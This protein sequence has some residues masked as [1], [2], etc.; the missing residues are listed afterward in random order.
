MALELPP[1]RDR[2]GDIPEL[3]NHFAKKYGEA[4]GIKIDGIAPEVLKILGEHEWRGNVRE[5]E[6]TMHRAVLLAQG[7]IIGP[8]AIML[9]GGRG[10]PVSRAAEATPSAAE[11]SSNKAVAAAGTAVLVGKTV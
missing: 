11:A 6:N 7:P 4:T 9:T 1:L 8:E 3:A 5:L 10:L 2:P